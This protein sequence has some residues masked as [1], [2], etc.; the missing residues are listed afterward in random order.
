MKLGMED[1]KKQL[2]KNPRD[3]Q[4]NRALASQYL[5]QGNY[6]EALKLYKYCASVAPVSVPQILIDFEEALVLDINNVAA[7]LGLVEFYLSQGKVPDAILEL[8][9]LVEISPESA[10][11][12]NLLGRIYLKIGNADSAISFLEK[13]TDVGKGDPA[14]LESLATAYLDKERYFEAA[15]LYEQ[16]LRTDPS[17]MRVLRT[18]CVLYNKTG[19]HTAAAKKWIDILARDPEV[20][21]EAYEKLEE[22]GKLSPNNPAVIESLALVYVRSLKPDKAVEQIARLVDLIPGS[23]DK[24]I[25]M[26]KDLLDTYPDNISAIQLMASNLVKKGSYSEAAELYD[27]IIKID[28]GATERCIIGYKSIIAAYPDQAMAHQSLADIYFARGDFKNALAEYKLVLRM[29][30][31][32]T[33]EIEK[34]VREILKA[35]PKAL[36]ALQLLAETLYSNSDFRKA[37]SLAEEIVQKDQKNTDALI[38]LGESYLKIDLPGKAKESYWQALQVLPFD[39]NLHERYRDISEKEL[40]REVSAVRSKIDQDPWRIG[41]NLDLARLLYKKGALDDAVRALQNAIRDASRAAQ[42]HILM[43]MIFKEQGRFDLALQQF[44]KIFEFRN[45]EDA[46]NEKT[47]RAH[48]GSCHEAIGETG[49]AISKYDEILSSDLSFGNLKT[50][51]E[52]LNQVNSSSLRNKCL[53]LFFADLTGENLRAVF[54]PD[55]R[56]LRTNQDEDLT[57]MSFGQGTNNEGIELYLKGRAKAAEEKFILAGQLDTALIPAKNNIA[58][59]G[60]VSGAFDS[61]YAALSS[62]VA[63]YKGHPVFHNNM[64]VY[65]LVKGELDKAEKDFKSS[66]KSDKDFSLGNMNM[67]DLLM[68]RSA[69]KEAVAYYKK[70]G[71]FDPL[72]EIAQRKLSYWFV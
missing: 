24:A 72:Y 29:N 56:R 48:I 41:L 38:V 63:E 3:A 61:A 30:P 22:L 34:K 35:N 33:V 9:E 58:V 5:E 55:A 10:H 40:A 45:L 43:G 67:G 59:I 25:A 4:V 44:E 54:G 8:E 1:L 20:L 23:L 7:R 39:K 52:Y 68:K 15:S 18:L 27:K 69:V 64:G 71:Q 19:D 13:A 51:I 14:L 49:K 28:S 2:K 12:Y 26:L 42:S 31:A 6:K 60:M 57:L 11:V 62:S 53:G 66:L 36:D 70:I 50:R 16:L 32:E 21:T 37:I 47:A 46:D 65:W 17:S